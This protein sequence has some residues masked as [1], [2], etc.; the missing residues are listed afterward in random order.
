MNTDQAGQS[1]DTTERPTPP[2]NNVLHAELASAPGLEVIVSVVELPP[3]TTLPKHLHPGEEFA[4]VMEG[5]M[6]LWQEGK[7]DRALK[8]GD[9]GGVPLRQVHTTKTGAEGAKLLVFRV[10]AKGEPE[11][12]PVG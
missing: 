11:R 8:A 4:Y 9:A 2:L 3:H 1:P 10:H 7:P 12:I 5:S 6:V